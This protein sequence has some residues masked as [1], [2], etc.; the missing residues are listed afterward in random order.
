[1]SLRTS[2]PPSEIECEEKV[3]LRDGVHVHAGDVVGLEA[4]LLHLVVIDDD[5]FA[6]E[7]PR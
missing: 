2:R 5:A 7:R 6:A 3:A 4:L 1:M